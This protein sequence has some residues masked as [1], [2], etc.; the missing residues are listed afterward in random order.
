[1]TLF[2]VI[3]PFLTSHIFE[4]GFKLLQN[5][6]LTQALDEL[7]TER[8]NDEEGIVYLPCEDV[9]VN[10]LKKGTISSVWERERDWERK[11]ER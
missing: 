5:Q 10:M 3:W 7:F 2:L 1:M 11:M 6:L 4:F 9:A 8:P